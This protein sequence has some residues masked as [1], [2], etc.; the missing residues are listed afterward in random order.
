MVMKE[1][2]EVA[3]LTDRRGQPSLGVLGA[4]GAILS[5]LGFLNMTVFL[6]VLFVIP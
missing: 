4:F 5:S 6:F 2:P 1:E 3:L